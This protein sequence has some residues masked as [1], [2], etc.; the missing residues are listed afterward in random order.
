MGQSAFFHHLQYHYNTTETR[1]ERRVPKLHLEAASPVLRIKKDRD[2]AE[3]HDD[4][5]I[6]GRDLAQCGVGVVAEFSVGKP[7]NG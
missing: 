7:R 1:N 3:L 5:P 4:H 6:S 2:E